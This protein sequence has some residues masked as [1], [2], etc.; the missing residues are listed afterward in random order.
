VSVAPGETVALVGASGAGKSTIAKL[1][2][3]FY[4]PDAGVVR[5]DGRDL[6]SLKLDSVRRNVAILLQEQLVL[7]GTVR[8][9]IGFGSERATEAD[10]IAAARA[11]GAHEFVCEL[12]DGYDTGLGERGRR[13]SGGQRQRIAIA[14]ALVADSPVLLLDEPSTGLDAATKGEL[15][16]PLMRL[17]DERTTI[18][19]SH[20]LLTTRNADHVV[21][22]DAG[23]VAERGTHDELVAAGGIYSHLWALQRTE[24]GTDEPVAA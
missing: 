15:V 6:R 2:L 19:I 9:N 8:E 22:L 14:R 10:V 7:H 12:P 24:E 11:A 17:T 23:R 5:L 3:R 21:V 16:E 20:D 1:L 4:D 13:L 18:V